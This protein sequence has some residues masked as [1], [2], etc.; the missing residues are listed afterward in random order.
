M[1]SQLP[2]TLSNKAL[3]QL[4]GSSTYHWTQEICGVEYL[5]P[6]YTYDSAFSADED[7]EELEEE[8]YMN[9]LRAPGNKPTISSSKYSSIP[10]IS[11]ASSLTTIIA[12]IFKPDN[13]NS[14]SKDNEKLTNCD[15]SHAIDMDSKKKNL[16]HQQF[17]N[18]NNSI[19]N[20]ILDEQF[21]SK[22]SCLSAFVNRSFDCN[23]I[24]FQFLNK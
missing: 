18:A 19:G 7:F 3:P 16:F 13:S 15:A 9:L 20:K 10:S 8:Y 22:S 12:N 11:S 14:F 23:I 24:D 2:T 6:N 5:N 21:K 1:F 17:E 4:P